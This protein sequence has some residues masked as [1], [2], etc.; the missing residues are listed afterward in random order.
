MRKTAQKSKENSKDRRQNR[1][2]SGATSLE[3]FFMTL[4]KQ[5]VSSYT[6]R[7]SD[8]YHGAFTAVCDAYG[9]IEAEKFYMQCNARALEI[10]GL[11][12]PINAISFGLL[13]PLKNFLISIEQNTYNK[14]VVNIYDQG[15]CAGCKFCEQLEG[16][17]TQAMGKITD[18]Y[19][20]AVAQAQAMVKQVSD[21]ITANVTPAVQKAQADLKQV[22][23]YVNGQVTNAVNNA[24]TKINAFDSQIKADTDKINAII[25]DVNSKAQQISEIKTQADA[26]ITQLNDAIS[27]INAMIP[28]LNIHGTQISDLYAKLG[29][30]QSQTTQPI[31]GKTTSSDPLDSIKNLFK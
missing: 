2:N 18:A 24:Q 31:N 10:D 26:T 5:S 4:T 16:Q 30:K 22:S 21:Y 3:G 6:T 23:D 9:Q 15:A 29:A 14:Q 11:F 17:I 25:S 27:K 19:N 12:A 13:N 1:R 28:T 20:K 7:H 8:W